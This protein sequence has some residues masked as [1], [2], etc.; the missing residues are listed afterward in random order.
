MN[1]KSKFAA[2]FDI[3]S[4]DD[5]FDE[6]NID[7]LCN[8]MWKALGSEVVVERVPTSVYT[9]WH[10]MLTTRTTYA[11]YAAYVAANSSATAT[12][13]AAAYAAYAA[14]AYDVVDAYAAMRAIRV[15]IRLGYVFDTDAV[16]AKMK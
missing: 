9:S 14:Y 12:I 5:S 4:T 16:F 6:Y 15:C 2:S 8:E 13:A 10:H 1:V 7:I 3:S 11:A